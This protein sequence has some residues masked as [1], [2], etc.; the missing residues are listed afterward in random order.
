MSSAGE[1]VGAAQRRRERRLRSMPRYE[2]Q[3]THTAPATAL[4]H[5]HTENGAPRSQST[6]TRA[7]GAERGEG[8]E[9]KCT[10]KFRK[11]PP[12][13]PELFQS[14]EEEPGGGRPPCLGESPGPQ[15]R[16]QRHTET[17]VPVPVLD[18]PVPQ[19]V[20]QQ[21]DVLKIID[22]TSPVE[23]V[24]DVPKIIQD[25]IPQHALLRA[26]QLVEQLVDV[27]TPSFHESSNTTRRG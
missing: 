25:N 12:P 20:D 11:T 8:D 5:S 7:G 15:E 23:Q 6:A 4:Q 22:T 24:I 1:P 19:S 16:I 21:V 2:Q 18:V 13:Q 10:A 27:P 14:Y 3:S 9:K 17:F 26:P